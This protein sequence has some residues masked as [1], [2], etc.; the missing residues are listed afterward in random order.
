MRINEDCKQVN[1]REELFDLASKNDRVWT[2]DEE[3]EV[4]NLRYAVDYLN[5][6]VRTLLINLVVFMDA[7]A[8]FLSW[9]IKAENQLKNRN[10]IV[11][12]CCKVKFK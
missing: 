3:G 7:L 11:D 6:D 1:R 8:K 4:E 5:L 9:T 12:A 2:I 10:L